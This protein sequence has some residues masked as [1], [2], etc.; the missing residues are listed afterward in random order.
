MHLGMLPAPYTG[1]IDMYVL[2]KYLM[3]GLARGR[4]RKMD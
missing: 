1:P 3:N 2:N 4:E